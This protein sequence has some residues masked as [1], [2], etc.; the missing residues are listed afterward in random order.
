MSSI[1][2]CYAKQNEQKCTT[3][4]E[5][6]LLLQCAVFIAARSD[7]AWD[8]FE[9]RTTRIAKHQTRPC[10]SLRASMLSPRFTSPFSTKALCLIADKKRWFVKTCTPLEM[11]R[12]VSVTASEHEKRFEALVNASLPYFVWWFQ[13]DFR[14][15][16]GYMSSPNLWN[17]IFPFL[18]GFYDCH[19]CYKV[20][21]RDIFPP[22][23]PLFLWVSFCHSFFIPVHWS[24]FVPYSSLL[25]IFLVCCIAQRSSRHY[26]LFPVPFQLF[27]F[28]VPF[29]IKI[30]KF[31]EI[32]IAFQSCVHGLNKQ[33]GSPLQFWDY[34]I[35]GTLFLIFSN[36]FGVFFVFLLYQILFWARN[37][38]P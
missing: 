5:Y 35:T 10:R 37:V 8:V 3:I 33:C 17:F 34:Y 2:A 32:W 9:R 11:K 12:M 38:R 21:I 18:L 31:C 29:N 23:F 25:S 24:T 19:L 27:F 15:P 14:S 28:P 13:V 22:L 1:S 6:L 20:K 7:G 16:S 4:N 36:I 26:L 30:N